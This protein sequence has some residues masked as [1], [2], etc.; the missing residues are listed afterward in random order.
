[1][2]LK[3]NSDK[4]GSFIDLIIAQKKQIP[5]PNKYDNW[6]P[7]KIKGT[8]TYDPKKCTIAECTAYE[9]S[10]IPGPNKYKP[11]KDLAT[12]SLERNPSRTHTTN[13][14]IMSVK[15]KPTAAPGG[16]C[17]DA[18]LNANRPRSAVCLFNREKKE[19]FIMKITRKVKK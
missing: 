8:Y 5:P 2:G 1:M 17:N 15:P 18:S 6:I 12:E 14:P 11:Y 10:F 3:F 13:E 19:T 7:P 9:K 4:S 16:A